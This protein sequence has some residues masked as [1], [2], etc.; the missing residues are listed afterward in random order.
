[1]TELTITQVHEGLKKKEFSALELAQSYL[2]KIKK[3]DGKVLAFLSLS[4]NLALSVAKKIDEMIEVA[5]SL[6]QGLTFVRV[7]LYFQENC[8]IFGEMTLYP[9]NGFV[10]FEPQMWDHKLGTYLKI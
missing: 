8:I 10:P 5:E 7:D 1:M 4:E 2:E 3:E 6:A 9:G